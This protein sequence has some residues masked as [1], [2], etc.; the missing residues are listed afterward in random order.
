MFMKKLLTSFS[1]LAIIICVLM[2]A[3][4]DEATKCP[5]CP[6]GSGVTTYQV[7]ATVLGPS[8]AP[9]GG[10]IISLVNPP[11][12]TGKFIDT[13]DV[14]GQGTIEAPAGAQTINVT[15][16]TVFQTTINVTVTAT[17]STT[18]QS[19]GTVTLHQNTSLG[20]TLVIFA[21]CEQIEAVLADPSIAYTTYDHT[22]VD[23]M[24]IRVSID[25]VAVL[26]YLKQYAIVFSD[27]N[28]G[29]EEDYPLLARVYGQYVRQGGKIYGGHYNYMNLQYIFAPAYNNNSSVSGYG[30]SLKITNT[31]LSAALGYSVI[32]FSSLS[33]FEMFSEIPVG[34]ST[35]YAVMSGSAGSTSSPQGIPIIVENRLGT[36]KYVWTTYHNQ[37]ILSDPQL[38]KI[39]RY[40]LYNM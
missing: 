30:D 4:C 31:I 1:M 7:T 23:S 39:V 28:C 17:T 32:H 24:R 6:A 9:Q 5:V 15:M 35:V 16:G 25:S 36:G 3:G 20:K 38:V 37:N 13:T 26:N 40:F 21:G 12:Q 27:C 8:G 18:P 29:D 34:N 10:A 14:N 11:N 2:I 19:A 22:T 33:G